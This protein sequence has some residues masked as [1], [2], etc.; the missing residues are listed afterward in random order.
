[1]SVL[2]RHRRPRMRPGAAVA[3]VL[4]ACLLSC[5]LPLQA[6]NRAYFNRDQIALDQTV[7]LTIE[8][9]EATRGPPDVSNL[10]RDFDV[11][12][13]TAE[14]RV[15]LTGGRMSMRVDMLLEMQP[16]RQ[17]WIEIPP[18]RVGADVVGPLR[19]FVA[20]P[21][22]APAPV[23]TPLPQAGGQ[24]E[25]PTVVLQSSIDSGPVYVQQSAG[26]VV[27]LYFD[28]SRLLEG[29]LEQPAPTG[30]SLLRLGDDIET[31]RIFGGRPYRIIER[32]FLLVPNRAG[33]VDVP[34]PKFEGRGMA[35]ILGDM[36]GNGGQNGIIRVTG[37][38]RSLQARPIPANAPQPWLPVRGARLRYLSAERSPRVGEATKV[39]V[40]LMMD[41]ANAVLL[42]EIRLQAAGD[43]QIFPEP[44]TTQED[45]VGDRPRSTMVREFSVVPEKPGPLRLVGPRIVW[46]DV[47]AGVARTAALPDL[48]LDVAPA[49]A[50]NGPVPAAAPAA[51]Q[52]NPLAMVREGG[53]R[54]FGGETAVRDS[55]A[56]LVVLWIVVLTWIGW[57]WRQR[58]RAGR[59]VQAAVATA[60]HYDAFAYKRLFDNG[61]LAEIT[62]ALCA[63][64]QPQAKDLDRL[65]TMLDD[66]AQRAAIDALQRA[67][68]GDGGIIET[69]AQLRDAFAQG[70]RWRRVE[71]SRAPSI[72]PPL[73]PE[74]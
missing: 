30:A 57:L 25:M 21:I 11:I 42:P 43:A 28:A 59:A 27:R 41:G 22:R 15:D 71:R 46:W 47:K 16:K 39:T 7:V 24:G 26:Y 66:P 14:P 70:P 36:F 52:R 45:F 44:A 9:E 13:I 55:I 48:R 8:T 31:Q 56:I 37:E 51:G 12:N 38:A 10:V 32:R 23:P 67:R 49:A 34:A 50:Q 63:M 62:H 19:L 18:F 58:R 54:R 4:L 1:M 72:L 53:W 60:H 6:Q 2:A 35:S 3:I 29:E 68:W 20:P 69:R 73:Y 61:S 65:R 5:V 40:E 17:G 33:R 74:V 64:A